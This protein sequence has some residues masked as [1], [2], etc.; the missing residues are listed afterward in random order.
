[1]KGGGD[2]QKMIDDEIEKGLRARVKAMGI[3]GISIL[4]LEYVN[5]DNYPALEVSWTPKNTY[6]PSAPGQF[7]QLITSIETS[8]RNLEQLDFTTL[9]KSMERDLAAVEKLIN[10]FGD[11]DYGSVITNANALVTDLRDTNGKLKTFI[12]DAGGTL[13]SMNLGKVTGSAEKLMN[14]LRESVSRLD[15]GVAKLDINSVNET[16]ASARRSLQSFDEVMRGLKEYPSGFIFGDPPPP[17]K[18]V[19]RPKK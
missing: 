11:V 3:T 9:G 13:K 7:S 12:D 15:A 16:L 5:P 8:L 1:M 18:S 10:K 6:I 17:A 19:Q 2:R 14:D 4:S